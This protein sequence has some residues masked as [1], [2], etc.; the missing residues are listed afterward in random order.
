[1]D[2]IYFGDH[3]RLRCQMG[4]EAEVMVKLALNHPAVPT[5]GHTVHLHAPPQHMRVYL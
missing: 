3:L 2:V 1:M 5:P 4:A